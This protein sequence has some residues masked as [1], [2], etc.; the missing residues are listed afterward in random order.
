MSDFIEKIKGYELIDSRGNP[1][2][3]CFA[4]TNRG[5]KGFA[6]VPS[7]ASTGVHEAVELRDNDSKRY[8]GKSV[9]KAVSNINEIIYPALSTKKLSCVQSIDKF[10]IELD[11]TENKSKL[12]ANAVLAVSLACAK[13]LSNSYNL[14]L[15]RFIGGENAKTLPVPMMNI[16]NGG[17]HASNNVDIQ[18]FMI[19]PFGIES[20]A[21]RMRA[22]CEI[23]HSLG[24][25]LKKKGLMTGVGDE[26]GFAPN[27]SSD[28]EA[29]DCIM[30]A[31]YLAGYSEKEIGIALDVASSEWVDNGIYTLKKRGT[32]MTADALCDYYETLCNKYPIISI[33]DG[34][35]EDDFEG[36]RILTERLGEKIRLVGDDLFVTNTKRLKEG[37]EQGIANSIL[38]KLNQ[39]G[40]LSETLEVMELAKKYGYSNIVSHRS[41]ES[42]DTFIADLAVGVNAPFIKS[43]APC[44]SD[45]V[46]KYNR[47]LVIESEI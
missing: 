31:V 10:L 2:V 12:G 35:G 29:L 25:T 7:G 14:P 22:G 43:G 16:L 45:R 18:E 8:N 27:L 40:T 4:V 32:V 11:G 24:K 17:A 15:Y 3:A 21:E 41:G 46:A 20:F 44:R 13:A 26:G 38:I 19:V 47:L 34:V 33:E 6:I 9:S 36:W 1:T 30:E 39:I 37:I 23:Y 42:E 5:A 28:E